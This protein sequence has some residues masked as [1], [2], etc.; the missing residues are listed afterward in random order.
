MP[1]IR[2]KPWISAVRSAAGRPA[3][4]PA[5]EA[6]SG[7]A[8]SRITCSAVEVEAAARKK[9]AQTVGNPAVVFDPADQR[10]K[11]RI[12]LDNKLRKAAKLIVAVNVQEPKF[13]LRCNGE[14]KVSCDI[15]G[16]SGPNI[17]PACFELTQKEFGSGDLILTIELPI[18]NGKSKKAA[19]N[20]ITVAPTS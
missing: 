9:E 2:K 1:A 19:I 13:V 4:Y 5:P 12:H 16:F 10:T 11:C 6:R 17:F 7:I 18:V 14:I 3:E 20:G 15:T 8:S